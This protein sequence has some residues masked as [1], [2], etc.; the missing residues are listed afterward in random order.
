MNL[1]D[2]NYIIPE[3]IIPY[4]NKFKKEFDELAENDF[5]SS[6]S[7]QSIQLKCNELVSNYKQELY[8][9]QHEYSELQAL[10]DN[11]ETDDDEYLDFNNDEPVKAILK[12]IYKINKLLENNDDIINEATNIIVQINKNKLMKNLE[13]NFIIEYTP[14][15]NVIMVYNFNTAGF[16]YFSDKSIS[17]KYLEA[18]CRK[19]CIQFKCKSL[20]S[21]VFV[22][23]GKLCN[24]SFLKN[25]IN[26]QIKQNAKMTFSDF[27]KQFALF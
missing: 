3:I 9:L 5:I 2:Q 13:N 7:S 20:F 10:Y 12:K 27:K 18:V 17:N 22:N 24:F 6:I 14:V 25:E 1:K 16:I 8:A 23:N 19:Y 4:E 21:N 11:S 15:G 26:Q